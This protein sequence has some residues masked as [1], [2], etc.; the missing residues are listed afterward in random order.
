M[1]A[2]TLEI[3]MRHLLI[4]ALLLVGCGSS[5]EDEKAVCEE[6]IACLAEA[7]GGADNVFQ[8]TYGEDGTCWTQGSEQATL[9]AAACQDT[10]DLY[11]AVEACGGDPSLDTDTPADTDG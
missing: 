8:A 4:T 2:R 10:L 5:Y 11:P 1:A 3:P 9:C 6:A 7:A